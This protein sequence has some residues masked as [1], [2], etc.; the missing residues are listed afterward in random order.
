[1]K[2]VVNKI[3]E[4]IMNNEPSKNTETMVRVDGFENIEIYEQ[5]AVQLFKIVESKG[6][7]I[8]VKLAKNKWNSFKKKIKNT[9]ALQF[10]KQNGWV[11]EEDSMTHYRNIHESNIVVLMG[12]ENEEDKGGLANIQSITPETLV[13]SLN[14]KYH[15]MFENEIFTEQDKVLVDRL[16]K[17]VFEYEAVDIVKLSDIV[18]LWQGKITNIEDF[19]ELFFKGLPEWGMP[20]WELELPKRQAIMGR[21]NILSGCHKFIVRDLFNNKM[22]IIQY[23]KYIERIEYYNSGKAEL[24]KYTSEHDC[25][26]NQ[27]IKSYDEFSKILREFI[28]G[29]NLTENKRKLLGVDYCIVED[30]LGIGVPTEKKTPKEKVKNLVGEPLEVFANALFITLAHIKNENINVSNIEFKFIQAEIVSM[31]SGVEDEEEKQQLL[32]SWMSI[33]AHCGGIIEVNAQ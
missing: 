5:V 32:N 13:Q 6:L 8:N 2:Y 22:S 18:D 15:L 20:F 17:D 23:N 11:A 1:M 30:V 24:A 31:Y 16:Y 19:I 3:I 26:T 21:R 9:T 7:T 12:T 25:W 28:I 14:G 33:C 27:K 10:M 4:L 29:E